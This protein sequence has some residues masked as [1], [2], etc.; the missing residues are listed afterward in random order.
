[1][2]KPIKAF[3]GL[4]WKGWKKFAH[5]LGI[6]NTHILLTVS[7]FII[8]AFASI[9][10]RLGRQDL[11]DRKMKPAESLYHPREVERPTLETAKRLF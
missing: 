10:T 7:Y 5:V 8:L 2:F 3:L 6:V 4:L 9:V 1:M 11:L